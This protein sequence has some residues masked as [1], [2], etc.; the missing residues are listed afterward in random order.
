MYGDPS[1]YKAAYE[2][3]LIKSRLKAIKE[4]QEKHTLTPEE[5]NALDENSILLKNLDDLWSGWF[6][7][8]D[9]DIVE[10]ES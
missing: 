1:L 9:I 8:K 7:V 6:P 3:S 4:S 10:N 2:K 5:V